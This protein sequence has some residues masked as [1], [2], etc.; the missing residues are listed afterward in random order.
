[1]FNVNVTET[2][3]LFNYIFTSLYYVY[4]LPKTTHIIISKILYQKYCN[5][6]YAMPVL[7]VSVA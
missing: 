1:M 5:I 3:T 2:I 6:C 4:T 7:A